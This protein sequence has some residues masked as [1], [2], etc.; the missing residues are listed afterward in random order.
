MTWRVLVIIEQ[1]IE[2]GTEKE[3]NGDGGKSKK[4]DSR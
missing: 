4:R 2:E 3:N 1:Y